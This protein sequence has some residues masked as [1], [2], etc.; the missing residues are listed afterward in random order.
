M[1]I[2]NRYNPDVKPSII[3]QARHGK[4]IIFWHWGPQAFQ[5]SN[6]T[7]AIFKV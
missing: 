4:R 1:K 5:P 3:E 7:I 6:S 2:V